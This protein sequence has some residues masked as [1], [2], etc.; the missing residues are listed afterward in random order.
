MRALS[1]STKPLH[2][3]VV[4]PPELEIDAQKML[5][6]GASTRVTA[7][8]Q[9]AVT[10]NAVWGLLMRA[11][12]RT[13][14]AL[15]SLRLTRAEI[16]N[17]TP[18][19]I[20][21]KIAAASAVGKSRS[22]EVDRRR[23]CSSV[24]VPEPSPRTTTMPRELNEKMNTMAEANTIEFR[25][26]GRVIVEKTRIGPAPRVAAVTSMRRS[27]VDHWAP[28]S[29]TT[30]AILMYAWAITTS[31]SP[32]GIESPNSDRNPSATTTVGSTKGMVTNASMNPRPRN[33]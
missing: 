32:L 19:T 9:V 27:R 4:R 28:T 7:T 1:N 6:I 10:A 5:A 15:G 3:P 18:T 29:R 21:C 13:I 24:R 22:T 31:S 8:R 11:R 26:A 33:W 17:T 23:T 25:S 14:F 12:S 20:S 16:T 30:T 2:Q